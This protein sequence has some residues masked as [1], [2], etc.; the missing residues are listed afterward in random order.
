MSEGK[1]G[2]KP[3][4]SG[5]HLGAQLFTWDLRELSG[6]SG[7]SRA[8]FSARDTY[9]NH[10]ETLKTTTTNNLMPMLSS[11]TS[12]I[13]R[14]GGRTGLRHLLKISSWFQCAPRVQNP[15]NWNENLG[16]LFMDLCPKRFYTLYM[17]H[18]TPGEASQLGEG[19]CTPAL[20]E[21][22]GG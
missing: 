7:G 19:H 3:D 2:M 21:D 5:G 8:G 16:S 12:W 4:W 22:I 14:S 6:L 10:L 9:Q 20:T 15:Q 13:R 18:R 17:T 11:E 1:E